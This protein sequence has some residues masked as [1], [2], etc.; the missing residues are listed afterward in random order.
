MGWEIR[1]AIICKQGPSTRTLNLSFAH[2]SAKKNPK[3]QRWTNQSLF[4]LAVFQALPWVTSIL[5]ALGRVK[6]TIK[7]E[8]VGN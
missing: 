7:I 8:K 1:Q 3:N 2:E 4:S 5:L 6:E